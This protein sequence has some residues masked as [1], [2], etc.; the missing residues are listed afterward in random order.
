MKPKADLASQI[1]PDRNLLF[2]PRT[3]VARGQALQHPAIEEM[4]EQTRFGGLRDVLQVIE[5]TPA[6][7]IDQKLAIVLEERQ[8]HNFLILFLLLFFGDGRS[9]A[10]SSRSTASCT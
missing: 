5:L 2:L 3:G 10:F 7:G 4:S 8:I 6:Q 9:R 1:E